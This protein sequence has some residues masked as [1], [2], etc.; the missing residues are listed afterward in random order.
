MLQ[1]GSVPTW[2]RYTVAASAIAIG[3]VL[4]I[5]LRHLINSTTVALIYLLVVLFL[6]ILWRSGPAML[7]SV[8]AMLC[9]NFFFLPSFHTFSIADPQNW[10]AL[11]VFLVAA[12]AVGQ[13]SARAKRRAEE[14]EAAKSEVERLYDDLQL[15]AAQPT[16][17][18]TLKRS[19]RQ[20]S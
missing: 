14:A 18:K 8:L 10:L 19:R 13:L 16:H 1:P 9:F 11:A 5:P 20:T 15:S 6:A 17:A 12:I 7:A 2:A 4:F 3:T